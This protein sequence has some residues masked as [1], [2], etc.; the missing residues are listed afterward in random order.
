MVWQM[1][2]RAVMLKSCTT[3]PAAADMQPGLACQ[4][5]PV[6]RYFFKVHC[7]TRMSYIIGVP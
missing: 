2:G 7:N 4:C 1:Q 3:A 6:L 5:V